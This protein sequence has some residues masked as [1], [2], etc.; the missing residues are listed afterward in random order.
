MT[1]R[2][3]RRTRPRCYSFAPAAGFVN[4]VAAA[5]VGALDE[6]AGRHFDLIEDLPR[7]DLDFVPVGAP[8]SIAMITAHMIQAEILWVSRLSGE[9]LADEVARTLRGVHT[10]PPS[11][12]GAA[13]L[14]VLCRQVREDVTKPRLAPIADID[15]ER[16]DRK[17]TISVRGVLMHLVWHW[18]YHNGQAG[19][20]RML[21]GKDYAWGFDGRIVGWAGESEERPKD[22]A[23]GMQ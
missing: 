10:G 20:L 2:D 11:P 4:P 5:L 1:D 21:R 12:L 23:G 3:P 8:S 19:M 16:C 13:D 14:A 22:A 6:L 18:S 7:I 15:A 9:R 17:P